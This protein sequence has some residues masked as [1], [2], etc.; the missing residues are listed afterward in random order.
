MNGAATAGAL[1]ASGAAAAVEA[2]KASGA[3]V[4][5][6]P[7]DFLYLL[8]QARDPLVVMSQGGFLRRYWHYLFGYKGLVFYARSSDE[9]SLPPGVEL[10]YAKKIWIPS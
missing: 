4:R 9:L 2:I 8:S 7:E 1:A 10:V 3:I 5:V 6:G